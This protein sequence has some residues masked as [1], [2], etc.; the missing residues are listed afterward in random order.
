M[1]WKNVCLSKD[2]GDLKVQSL[3]TLNKAL[4]VNGAGDL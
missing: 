1:K 4:L 2:K 3:S